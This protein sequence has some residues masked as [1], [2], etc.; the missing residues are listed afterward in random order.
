MPAALIGITTSRT[1]SN[2][3]YSL[4]AA[5]EA[6]VSAVQ[7]AG[8]LPVLIPVGLDGSDLARLRRSL[9]GILLS[10]GGDVHPAR[11]G[12]QPHPAINGVDEQRDELEI[13]LVRL[14]AETGWP[15]FGICRGIQIINVALGG[16]LYTHLSD[17]LPGALRHDCY[18]NMPRDWTAHSVSI[19]P[20]SL[21]AQVTAGEE[22]A[23]NSLHHQGIDRLAPGLESLAVSPDGLIEAVQLKG[24]PF[25]LGVQWHP[26]WLPGSPAH[27]AIIN[28]FV[29]ALR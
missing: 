19:Q 14:A 15:F 12:G 5:P 9:D 27:H 23:V 4:I 20:G 18:P 3:N 29:E 11:F 21:L 1:L 24:H 6:Y 22:L 10:G 8:G 2:A 17:Q 25:G 7:L 26:E 13:E 28:S 16:S